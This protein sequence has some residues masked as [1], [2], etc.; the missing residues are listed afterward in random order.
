LSQPHVVSAYFD[1]LMSRWLDDE[2]VVRLPKLEAESPASSA[3]PA[4]PAIGRLRFRFTGSM[5][6]LFGES[7]PTSGKYRVHI[8]GKL[9]EKKSDDGKS[10]Q[11]EFD[12]GH[13]ARLVKGNTHL[14]K[15]IVEGL[16]PSVEHTLEI[17]PVL[18]PDQELRIESLC[19]AGG[20][21]KVAVARGTGL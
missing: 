12:A 10:T 1:M 19:I 16:D 9:V 17:E 2:V 20:T 3:S 13:L 18:N 8:D 21:A 6:M 4:P 14:A 11:S 5:A 7:T 15:V